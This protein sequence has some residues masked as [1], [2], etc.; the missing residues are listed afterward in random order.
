MTEF[1]IKL[2]VI[3]VLLKIISKTMSGITLGSFTSTLGIATIIAILGSAGVYV[4]YILWYAS[5]GWFI[6][7]GTNRYWGMASL[8]FVHFMVMFISSAL[9]LNW[10]NNPEKAGNSLEIKNDFKGLL[11]C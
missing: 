11:V 10:F 1:I 7:S 2:L 6:T 5:L 8:F 4:G 9:V 3:S